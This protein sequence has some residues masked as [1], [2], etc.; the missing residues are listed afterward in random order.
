MIRGALKK[1]AEIKP[2]EPVRVMLER[3][4]ANLNLLRVS[5]RTKPEFLF[6][7]FCFGQTFFVPILTERIEQDPDSIE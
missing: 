5:I 4:N 2:I 7:M 6:R 1:Q 3:E